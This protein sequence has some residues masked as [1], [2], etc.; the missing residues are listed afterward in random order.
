MELSAVINKCAW[1]DSWT[2]SQIFALE[3]SWWTD[4]RT[5]VRMRKYQQ[6]FANRTE[7]LRAMV[8]DNPCNWIFTQFDQS[9]QPSSKIT[10]WFKALKYSVKE[11]YAGSTSTA[12]RMLTWC[13]FSNKCWRTNLGRMEKWSFWGAS[14]KNSRINEGSK[15]CSLTG[16][17]YCWIAALKWIMDSFP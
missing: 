7:W 3:G 2:V 8:E 5:D 14:S 17:L 13:F 6:S 1:T 15:V 9:K 12:L 4:L 11:L 10:W 16:W